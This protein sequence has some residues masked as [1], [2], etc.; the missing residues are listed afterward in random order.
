MHSTRT[1]TMRRALRGFTLTEAGAVAAAIAVA[2]AVTVPVFRRVG[3]SAGRAQSAAQ[4]ATLASA[5]AAYAA[6]FGDRQYT[7]CPDDLGVV[8]GSFSS[9][10]TQFGCIPNMTI[11]TTSTG[12][13]WILG[14]GTGACSG[15]SGGGL[16]QIPLDLSLGGTVGSYRWTN[17]REFNSY[18]NGRFYDQT[19][20]APDDQAMTRKIQKWINEERDFERDAESGILNTTYDYSPAA[21][22]HPRVFGDGTS[23][24]APSFQ[25]PNFVANG[26][27][28]KSPS[29]SQCQHPALKTRLLERHC[30]EPF[31]GPNP[32][33]S[34][35]RTPYRWNQ[36][37]QSRSQAL[38]FDGSVRLFTTAEAMDSEARSRVPGSTT[39]RAPLWMRTTPFGSL[40]FGGAQADDFLVNTSVHYLTVAGIRGRDTLSPP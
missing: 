2:T 31:L 4:L 1:T 36:S 26:E 37:F 11:G 18:V 20:Y 8:G 25:S 16:F 22:Y 40:G 19:F 33:Y 29:N 23:A 6:D 27:G 14:H 24:S 39:I 3:C 13:T 28:Y 17:V 7:A 32:A 10:Q 38:F 34:G 35:G 30:M 21:M 5:H 9:Y 12:Q 15:N